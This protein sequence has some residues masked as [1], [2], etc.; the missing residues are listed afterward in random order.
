MS[1]PAQ[2]HYGRHGQPQYGYGGG[3]GF[4]QGA[5]PSQQAP[6]R[7]YTPIPQG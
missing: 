1:Q 3:G 6:G 5:V 4:P 2:P 7:Y